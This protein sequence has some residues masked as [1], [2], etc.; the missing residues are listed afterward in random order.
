MVGSS[1]IG[2]DLDRA[3]V[4]IRTPVRTCLSKIPAGD[5]VIVAC[6]GGADSLALAYAVAQEAPKL[7]LAPIG[8]TID[9]QL[10]AGS[11]SQAERVVAQLQEMGIGQAQIVQVCV[12]DIDG[13][14]ASARRV[15]YSALDQISDSHGEAAILLGHT[16]DDQ[17]E[18]VLLGLARGSG[19]RSLSAMARQTG[20]YLRPLLDISREQTL[21]ACAQVGL[22]PW[23]DPHNSD[24]Q[25][26]RVR[27]RSQ[28]LPLLE[29][30]IGPGISA[31]LARSAGLLRDDADALDGWA[32]REFAQMEPQSLDIQTLEL[33]PRAIR[34]RI[35]RLA[36][37]VAGAPEGSISADHVGAV[38]ALVVQWH[39][40]GAIDLP[41][42]VKAVR[43]SG[44]LSL[45][46]P[47]NPPS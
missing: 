14:E 38:Q 19:T 27:V 47:S 34:N 28:V 20:R 16:R 41:G 17:A 22:T 4:A 29:E 24:L 25:F 30:A 5:S 35:I 9:H 15:R 43:I 37:Y 45:L 42:G 3:M 40:Q 12:V 18:G 39:G 31:A 46:P 6:S 33:L 32:Q 10:Q 44:R 2:M 26:R 1:L 11:R 8:V 21:A 36:I 23:S 7:A 13:I